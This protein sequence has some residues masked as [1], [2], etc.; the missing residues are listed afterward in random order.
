MPQGRKSAEELLGIK[1]KK[2]AEELLGIR[3][4]QLQ[5][6]RPQPQPV[7]PR[8]TELDF[9][10]RSLRDLPE[11]SMSEFVQADRA[12]TENPYQAFEKKPW[13]ERN[14]ERYG[15]AF[16][17][18][19]GA[20]SRA[21]RQGIA[22]QKALAK[23]T[24]NPLVAGSLLVPDSLLQAWG[25]DAQRINR[26]LARSQK[27]RPSSLATDVGEGI[28]EAIPA[29]AGVIGGSMLT[30]GGLPAAM[31]FGGG[32]GAAEADWSDPVKATA[33]TAL[34]AIAPVVG[35]KIGS[36]VGGAVPKRLARP[37]AQRLA[38]AA[39]EVAGGGLGNV[40]ATGA[41]QLAFEGGL[42]PRELAKSGL[43][44][45]G[46]T[47]PGA[48]GT[49]RSR[50]TRP[51][52]APE[53]SPEMLAPET[54]PQRQ[55]AE[56]PRLQPPTRTTSP[57][58]ARQTAEIRY[59]DAPETQEMPVIRERIAAENAPTAELPRGFG[60]TNRISPIEGYEGGELQR[61][62]RP[63]EGQQAE[64]P[65]RPSAAELEVSR[66]GRPVTQEFQ[67]PR[68][69]ASETHATREDARQGY[70]EQFNDQEL[71]DEIRRMEDVRNQGLRGKSN[72]SREQLEANRF[73]LKVAVEM[74]KERR[75]LQQQMGM[76]PGERIA[77]RAP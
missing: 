22:G 7:A 13:L 12:D 25:A 15:E 66:P 57:E 1:P 40:G 70:F 77:P 32:M 76:E 27:S 73:D 45:M 42:N 64:T 65:I 21:L 51:P 3:P 38:R 74:Q 60:L 29:T 17:R 16:A 48:I 63:L 61:Y 58:I 4:S 39:G 36:K 56:L 31:L 67:I 71:V 62:S 35:G 10:D 2:S 19:G 33:Q 20:V 53:V 75:R 18:G 43:I 6:P 55:T 47:A 46:L 68:L 23:R 52:T 9:S 8:R 72:L 49:M 30:G 44:G 5:Q 11:P 59:A 26:N 28:V 41:E 24:G 50:P 37:V 69:K 54:T 34:G 14:I